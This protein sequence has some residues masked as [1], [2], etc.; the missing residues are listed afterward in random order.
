MSGNELLEKLSQRR[1]VVEEN[2]LQFEST[3]ADS[4]ADH[5]TARSLPTPLR[6]AATE[7]SEN[8]S[9]SPGRTRTNSD[10]RV[11]IEK[12][13][14]LLE[15]CDNSCF[16]SMPEGQKADC[17]QHSGD[18][19]IDSHSPQR[20]SRNNLENQLV[21]AL[22]DS[23][24]MAITM[25][26]ADGIQH[27][28]GDSFPSPKGVGRSLVGQELPDDE[29]LLDEEEHRA[30]HEDASLPE[31]E[32]DGPPADGS[33]HSSD[34]SGV[35]PEGADRGLATQELLDE[36]EH[37]TMPAAKELA[38]GSPAH[39][40]RHSGDASGASD[41]SG[42]SVDSQELLDEEEQRTVHDD[43]DLPEEEAAEVVGQ[44]ADGSQHSSD[45]LAA[46]PDD[47]G[48]SLADQELLEEEE[49]RA[50]YDDANLAEDRE[51]TGV[52][53]TGRPAPCGTLS[54]KGSR[55]TWLLA[56][57]GSPLGKTYESPSFKIGQVE[58]CHLC[59]SCVRQSDETEDLDGDDSEGAYSCELSMHCG[60][61]DADLT[62]ILS[63]TGDCIHVGFFAGKQE[64]ASQAW[65][66]P[67]MLRS[68][69]S[70][71]NRRC[72][73]LC[74]VNYDTTEDDRGQSDADPQSQG[75]T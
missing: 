15:E 8:N 7:S 36:E 61:D 22:S 11:A 47:P 28:S 62:A 23:E 17:S 2:A 69:F 41:G 21:D 19:T 57:G 51:R 1:S 70:I 14:S 10:F 30:A 75:C 48:R 54:I 18:A 65:S 60:P 31:E 33:Q 3:P 74:G 27:S 6:T 39:S 35:F 13:R 4:V 25:P 64:K 24:Q 20:E 63:A 66:L 32:E 16:E 58:P 43:A 49:H 44:P 45:N 59:F 5:Q 42:I 67:Q 68:Q 71:E 46:S 29:E 53:A 40:D 52:A 37:S 38:P 73:I 9:L 12:Q 72:N 34:Q 26:A 50:V 56:F 55:I